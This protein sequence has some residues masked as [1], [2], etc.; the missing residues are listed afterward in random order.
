MNKYL[1]K[2]FIFATIAIICVSVVAIWLKYEGKIYLQLVGA[3]CL[4]FQVSQTL[5]DMKGG[6]DDKGHIG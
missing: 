5:T 2:R 3:I 4:I 1:G 6:K